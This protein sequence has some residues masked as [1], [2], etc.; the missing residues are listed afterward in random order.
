MTLLL[1][2]RKM[3]A[4]GSGELFH[5]TDQKSFH[6]NIDFPGYPHAFI[7]NVATM[8]PMVKR[9]LLEKEIDISTLHPHHG[10]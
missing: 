10:C 7:Y 9:F 8:K 6:R 5:L 1:R 4:M 2:Q 3:I